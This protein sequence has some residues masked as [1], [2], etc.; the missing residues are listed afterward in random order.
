MY[1][2]RYLLLQKEIGIWYQIYPNAINHG[3]YSQEFMDLHVV[4]NKYKVTFFQKEYINQLVMF[5]IELYHASQ[6][7]TLYFF[8]DLQGY[9][10]KYV[11]LSWKSFLKAIQEENISFNIVY[12]I[13]EQFENVTVFSDE[14]T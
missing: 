14:F 12:K 1:N 3:N 4:E 5:L 11:Q 7:K 9:E 10:E 13:C 6:S 2:D 8:V